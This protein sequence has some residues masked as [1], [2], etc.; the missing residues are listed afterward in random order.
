[1]EERTYISEEG[2]PFRIVETYAYDR[3]ALCH[4]FEQGYCRSA[5]VGLTP[6]VRFSYSGIG[7]LD[8]RPDEFHSTVKLPSF[9]LWRGI[10]A[11]V[12]KENTPYCNVTISDEWRCFSN[13]KK[14]YDQSYHEGWVIDKDLL[15]GERKTYSAETCTFMPLALNSALKEMSGG[16]IT[17]KLK[18]GKYYYHTSLSLNGKNY[19]VRADTLEEIK[20]I[21]ALQRCASIQEMVSKYRRNFSKEVLGKIDNYYNYDTYI[22]QIKYNIKRDG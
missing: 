6:N 12:G 20:R 11:R 1:M 13:F 14:F 2:F 8:V 21:Y 10:L 9:I 18:N 7:F 19:T 3:F 16:C 17:F 22:N 5:S 4:A 15:S